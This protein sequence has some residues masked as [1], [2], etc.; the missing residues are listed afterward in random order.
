M[1]INPGGVILILG[2]IFAWLVATGRYN[3]SK[4][5]V[6]GEAWRRQWGPKL[7]ILA[8]IIILFGVLQLFRIL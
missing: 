3:P 7:T 6:K 5:P 2:G 8:P 4:D 1:Q